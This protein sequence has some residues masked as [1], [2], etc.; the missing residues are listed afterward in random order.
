MNHGSGKIGSGPDSESGALLRPLMAALL[1]G[2]AVLPA[3]SQTLI[4]GQA[5][6]VPNN[7]SSATPLRNLTWT[8]ERSDLT[9]D[10][11]ARFG[12]L[13][14]G[15]R[16][17]IYR[18]A[19]PPGEAAIR[20]RIDAGDLMESDAQNGLAHFIEHMGFN[21]TTNI[22]E[23]ELLKILERQGLAFGPDT[24]AFT[25]PD[26]TV[27]QL[28]V[29]TVTEARLDSALTVLREFAGEMRFDAPSIE[30]ERGIIVSEDRSQY[31][32]YRRGFVQRNA[33][34]LKGQLISR[35]LDIGDLDVI[36][37]APRELFV[38]YYRKYY[39]PERATLVVVGD[40]D[41]I[42]VEAEIQRKF[43]SWKG[44]G[45]GGSD[46]DLGTVAQRG[47]EVGSFVMPG[48]L[49]DVSLTWVKP[50]EDE[51]D[52]KAE[53][54]E[55]VREQLALAVLNRRF[56]QL[57]A[58]G[59]APFPSAGVSNGKFYRSAEQT[60]ARA[61]PLPG[62]ELEATAV[63]EREVRRA[64]EH[65]VLASELE[66]EISE[67][68]TALV[69]AAAGAGTRRTTALAN[70]IVSTVNQDQALLSPKQ[71][72]DLFEQGVSG[73]TA[74]DA[75]TILKTLF[76]GSGP[77]LYAMSPDPIR[78]GDQAM[79][80][81][82]NAARKS[83][84]QPPVAVA[85]KA[86]PYRSFGTAGKVAERTEIAD[87]GVTQVRFANGVTLLVKPTAFQKDQVLVNVRVGGGRLALPKDLVTLPVTQGAFISGGVEGLTEQEMRQALVGKTY[88]AGFA[89]AD[90]GFTLGGA[91]R[92]EDFAT[93]LQ[94]LA[95]YVAK[96]GWRPEAFARKKAEVQNIYN[97][98]ATTPLNTAMTQFPRL[99]RSGDG[100]W[101]FPTV[102]GLNAARLEPVRD[103]VN[104]ELASAPIEVVIVG[105]VTV[106]QAIAQVAAS[107]GAFPTRRAVSPR[108]SAD[109]VQFTRGGGGPQRLEHSGRAD[110]AFGM[111]AWPTDDFHDDP[112]EARAVQLLRSVLQLRSIDKLREELG[113]TYSPV[114]LQEAS[115]I[116]DEFGL[117]AMGAEVNPSQVNPLL[118]AIGEVA[119]ELKRQPVT[120]DDLTRVTQP[121]LETLAKQRA[122]ND[123]W[124]SR[125]GGAAWDPR[126]LEIIRT[127]E[128]ALRKVTPADIQRV[129]RK[130]LRG[131][132]AYRLIVEPKLK[133]S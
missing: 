63:L 110:V 65:G 113:A 79:A 72:L 31:P 122:G 39:R 100:R 99:V 86:W 50:Y 35:R 26:Q 109:R 18:N 48:A 68:R 89:V 10:P 38:D 7:A 6:P 114:V 76:V 105:D 85:A 88:S 1:A 130:Y 118:S 132:A 41:P 80:Q 107:F 119:E 62:R 87:L 12:K 23:G 97:V 15:M 34:L 103:V 84:V 57:V 93:Q 75:G 44:E 131:D 24:N 82:F 56:E 14:N 117:I 71:S 51:P 95:A 112:A 17:I 106:D 40:V 33:F 129:S 133:A 22:K 20:L 126:R 73:F 61:E 116:F 46:P 120:A 5:S 92:P 42:K 81:A 77:L 83:A 125:L 94:V 115:E 64:V 124:A 104:R 28:D 13:A 47:F 37:T 78:G 111:I 43:S 91:T 74:A 49:R 54:I 101:G 127:Q 55:T 32:P 102:E 25:A 21:G 4:S 9:P 30:R 60:T 16:Y 98:V 3:W 58:T 11:A 123:Y 2:A 69:A 19:T 90:D 96:P 67:T 128:E 53:R 52:A 66:R 45:L 70:Q 27:Y 121:M 59:N 8:H 36:R 108:G 29:P